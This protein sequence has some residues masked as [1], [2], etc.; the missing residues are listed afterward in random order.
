M[1]FNEKG[2]TRVLGLAGSL[3]AG[4]LNKKLLL[5]ATGLAPAGME[6]GIFD[7]GSIPLYN[8]DV[9]QAGDPPPVAAFKDA[10]HRVDGLLIATPEYQHG[11]PGV[12]K[13]ALDWASRPPGKSVLQGK[14]VAIMGASPG[15]TGTARA[16]TQLRESFTFSQACAVLQ[17]EVIV[18]RAHEKFDG[19]GRLTDATTIQLVRK[20]LDELNELV[21]LLRLSHSKLNSPAAP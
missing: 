10:I 21:G 12:L 4:S 1:V 15:F 20:L 2:S 14:P 7:L 8:F 6:I 11:V 16:Q 5:A 17:P 18:G 3:R 13:N 9:E 19:D